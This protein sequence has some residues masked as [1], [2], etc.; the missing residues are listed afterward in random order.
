MQ[1]IISGIGLNK[2]RNGRHVTKSCRRKIASFEE[3]K[4]AEFFAAG[5]SGFAG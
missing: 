1:S 5:V 3:R 4:I 2:G